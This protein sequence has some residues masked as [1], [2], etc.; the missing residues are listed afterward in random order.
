M[1][2]SELIPSEEKRSGR[3]SLGVCHLSLGHHPFIRKVNMANLFTCPDSGFQGKA[4][5]RYIRVLS[6][7]RRAV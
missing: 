1:R 2:K 4:S 7:V 5:D 3:V 6:P